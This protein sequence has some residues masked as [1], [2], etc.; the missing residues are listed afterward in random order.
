[1]T[2]SGGAA[3]AV[4]LACLAA[5]L[6][7]VGRASYTADLSAFLPR[8][9]SA[10]QQLLI[11]Q[12]KS[13]IASRLILIGIEGGDG[14]ERAR[15]SRGLAERLRADPKFLQVANG[16]STGLARDRELLFE[17]RYL[18]SPAVGPERFEPAG[19]REALGE[20]LERLAGPAGLFA[21]TLLPRDPTGE[22]ARL[23]EGIGG[24]HRPRLA[25]GV[26]V[27]R[28]GARALL[29][30]RTGAA[31]A[32]TDGQASAVAAIESAFAAVASPGIA[33]AMT[34]PG[35]FSVAARALMKREILRLSGLG[36]LIVVALLALVYRSPL[37]VALGLLPVLSGAL[38]GA[39]A[40]GLGFVTVHGVTLGF[41][42]ALI[43][44]AVDYSIY[45]LMQSQW[46]RAGPA[47]RH[48][49]WVAD[50][51]PTV[52][53]GVLTSVVGFA[54]LLLSSFPG[55]AQLGLYA[56]A[57]LIA[58]A[59]VTRY[60]LPHL[61][62]EDLRVRDF[63]AFGQRLRGWVGWA[64]RLRWAVLGLTIAACAVLVGGREGLW[65]RELAA[66][67]PVSAADRALDGAM[68]ADLG[69]PDV[70]CLVLAQADS[71]EAALIAAERLGTMLRGLEAEGVIAGFESPA[72]FLPSQETQR[73]RQS[74]LPAEGALR[75][76]LAEA[77]A[78]LPVRSERFEPFIADVARARAQAPL[79][80]ADLAGTSLAQGLDAL[81]IESGG[82]WSALLPLRLKAGAAPDGARLR[83]ALAA[84]GVEGV[85]FIDLKGE[86]DR[87][88]AGYL[89][90]AIRLSLAGLAAIL[91]LLLALTRSVRRVLAIAAPLLAAVV[92]VAAGLVLAG[93][94]L[95]ILHLVGMLL[96][97]AVGSNYAL[98][99]DRGAVAGGLSA[100]TLAS[101]PLAVGTTVAGFGILAFS[102]VPVLGAIGATVGP[103]AVLALVFSAIL[104]RGPSRAPDP[105]RS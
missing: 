97:V 68:R 9:P 17:H 42:T 16:E 35:P 58:A 99:F 5:C 23:L 7:A 25:E 101:L 22:L 66:L 98:F 83:A 33:L 89:R 1:M 4:W 52:R 36:S 39:A 21:K 34:G 3:V 37:A 64:G 95:G 30:V 91:A 19:L 43:G 29:L 24:A 78:S 102:S 69:A 28:D 93:V 81:L 15:V 50:S 84:T 60:V 51:W 72:A 47:E 80:P 67:S 96:V 54:S 76:R 2:R 70:R 56:I 45:L 20:S 82:R 13:G 18:L 100:R 77:S 27:S 41:G 86:T 31:G 92:L 59:L 65:S 10:E 75:Q 105:P 73:R 49:R 103:G 87:L 38:A 53:I 26:W 63:E 62:P 8:A 32:D 71:S 12:L 11:D 104:T 14:A 6:W 79:A 74:S 55:L 90:Q 94:K 57:G 85:H 44:E 46:T 48:R 61:L 40:V 88:Y